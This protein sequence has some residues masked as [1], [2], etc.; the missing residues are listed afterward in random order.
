MGGTDRAQAD[1]RIAK[2]AVQPVTRLPDRRTPKG[3]ITK[4]EMNLQEN[5]E[6]HQRG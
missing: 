1:S 4:K 5:V 3:T 2:G 6:V